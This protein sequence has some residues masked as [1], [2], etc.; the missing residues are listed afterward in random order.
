MS[1]ERSDAQNPRLSRGAS[2]Q[3]PFDDALRGWTGSRERVF[4]HVERSTL[5][6]NG[7]WESIFKA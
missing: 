6:W 5:V 7:R 3:K 4:H 2:I 1:Q